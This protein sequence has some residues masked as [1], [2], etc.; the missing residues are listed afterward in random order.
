VTLGEG[1]VTPLVLG[2]RFVL[3]YLYYLGTPGGLMDTLRNRK[4]V[5]E[6]STWEEKSGF[7]AFLSTLPKEVDRFN[8]SLGF[9]IRLEV[10]P[11]V[12]IDGDSDV[13]KSVGFVI[14]RRN[15]IFPERTY[16][17]YS[18]L[19]D[20]VLYGFTGVYTDGNIRTIKELRPVRD[21]RKSRLALYDWMRELIKASCDK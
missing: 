4:V 1:S 18:V 12:E 10:S 15:S 16:C 13:S 11:P 6:A 21:F 14:T 19:E 5:F 17:I 8:Q 9:E 7:L 2:G 3:V 20:R